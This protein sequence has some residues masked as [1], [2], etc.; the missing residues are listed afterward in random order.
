MR[1]MAALGRITM[2]L[3]PVARGSSRGLG[4]GAEL[5]APAMLLSGNV[6]GAR[7]V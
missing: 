2:F 4:F 6:P 5:A 7:E 1:R 3:D